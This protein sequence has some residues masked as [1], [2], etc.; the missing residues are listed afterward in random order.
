MKAKTDCRYFLGDRPCHWQR[1]CEGC[2]Q[3]SPMGTRILII[4][5]AAAGDVLRTAAILAPLRREYPDS[6]V[7]WVTD[8]SALPLI[9]LNP[10]IDRALPLTFES[11]LILTAQRFDIVVC[12]DKEERAAALAMRVNAERRLGFGL[13][14]FGT[15]EPLNP[16]AEYDYELG[17]SNEMKFSSNR[18]TSPDIFCETAELEYEGDPYELTL[19]DSSIEYA[20]RFLSGLSPSTP[21]VGLN[22]GAGAVFARKAWTERGFADLSR[23]IAEKLGGTALLLGGPGEREAVAR[24]ADVSGGAA[25]DGGVHELLDFAAIV[26]RLDALVTGDT[27]ALHIAVALGVPVVA[28]FG[29]TVEQEI[30]LFGRGRKVVTPAECAPC[31]RRECSVSPSCMDLVTVDAVAEALAGVLED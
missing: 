14:N 3:Y 10:L 31:Y 18:R 12:L 9:A 27:M 5:L 25:L 13:N 1:V 30:E 15:V 16:G 8:T 26:G 23:F 29:P 28:I 20:D 7:T 21:L 11:V 19:P 17:L 24:I 4:K 6:Y 2:E 22:V